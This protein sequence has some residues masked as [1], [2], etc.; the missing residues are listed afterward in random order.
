[1]P[2]QKK[3][4]I[5]TRHRSVIEAKVYDRNEVVEYL[6]QHDWDLPS[7]SFIK[8]GPGE[9]CLVANSSITPCSDVVD[10]LQVLM[11]STVETAKLKELRTYK[12][13]A[14]VISWLMAVELLLVITFAEL[15]VIRFLEQIG[16]VEGIA[17]VVTVASFVILH[18]HMISVLSGH[19]KGWYKP[20][21]TRG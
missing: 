12:K 2:T 16:M 21:D 8:V 19:S 17:I 1:M 20:R 18:L 3:I 15:S 4:I 11:W 14:T 10:V 6:E 13:R 5:G 7:E 9:Y